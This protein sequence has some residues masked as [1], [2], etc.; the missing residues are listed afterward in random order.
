MLPVG[1]GL[2]GTVLRT[3][4]FGVIAGKLLDSLVLSKI[5]DK[6]D[7]KKW[8]RQTKLETYSQFSDKVLNAQAGSL[9][10]D[11]FK[12]LRCFATKSILLLED[13]KIINNINNYLYSLNLQYSSNAKKCENEIAK[14]DKKGLEII[15]HL[16]KN[17]RA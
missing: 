3:A 13:E 8:L 14:I 1:L 6:N 12:Q 5:N 2:V 9:S 16:N 17:L 15:Y 10:N 7:K 11:E 4:A